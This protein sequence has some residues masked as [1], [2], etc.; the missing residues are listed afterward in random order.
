MFKELSKIWPALNAWK[1]K[2]SKFKLIHWLKIFIFNDLVK[3]IVF[4]IIGLTFLLISLT[5]PTYATEFTTFFN[6]SLLAGWIP[7]LVFAILPMFIFAW[8]I[9]PIKSLRKK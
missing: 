9:N 5:Y 4:S 7:L 1:N 8:I 3:L 2:Q 6:I